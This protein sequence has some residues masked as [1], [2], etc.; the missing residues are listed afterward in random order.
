MQEVIE[1]F[2]ASEGPAIDPVTGDLL[3]WSTNQ[4][5]VIFRVSGFEVP[6]TPSPT[7]TPTPT[8]GACSFRVLIAHTNDNQPP[9]LLQN[10]ILAE[11]GVTQVDMFDA[12]NGTPT[13][14]Q[15][16]QYD[17]VFAF[18]D[19]A[20]NDPVEMGNVL[21]DYEDG[22]GVVIVGTF[23]WG[24]GD[25]GFMQGRWMTGGYS[26]FDPTNQDNFSLN[27][28]NITD[29][30][31]PLMQG[32]SSLASTFRNGL[33]LASGASA[34]AT[35]TDGP[36]AVAYKTSNGRTA[37]GIN[38]WLSDQFAGAWGRV[39]VNAGRWLP[40]CG[41]TPTPTPTPRPTRSLPTPRPRPTPIP[42]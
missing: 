21:A 37:V 39:I 17:I 34:V 11:P 5:G 12:R 7:P 8:P 35:W 41:A 42:R 31:H 9:T 22:G 15:L 40:P 25:G 20:W 27:I 19:T 30:F 10:E 24:T 18:S 13:L 32:V 33:P 16:Q 2:G 4:G 14:Q 23:A 29:P 3:F 28:A 26:P 1:G 6:P 38:A 36:P